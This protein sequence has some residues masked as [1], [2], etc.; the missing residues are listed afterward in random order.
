MAT[1]ILRNTLTKILWDKPVRPCTFNFLQLYNFS[2]QSHIKE[3]SEDQPTLLV[4]PLKHPDFFQIHNLFT[5]KDLYNARVHF[6]HKEGSVNQNMKPFIFGS[7]LGHLI[8]NLDKTVEMLRDALN[9]AA[10]IAFREG[11]ILFIGKN[12]R[13]TYL[14]DKTAIECGEYSH[15]RTWKEDLTSYFC[16]GFL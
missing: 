14:I 3:L 1:I 8:I 15:T 13:I 10:H 4:D 12:P 7:R 6:G 11:V 16:K 2:T 5:V 9:F